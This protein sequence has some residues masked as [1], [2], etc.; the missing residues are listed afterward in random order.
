MSSRMKWAEFVIRFVVFF[1]VFTA[2]RF[3]L[4]WA[5]NTFG[6]GE[7]V[8]ICAAGLVAHWFAKDIRLSGS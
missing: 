6:L 2:V 1:V 4:L 7:I 8:V 3:L 5:V